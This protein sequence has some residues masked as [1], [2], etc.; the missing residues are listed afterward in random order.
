[1]RVIKRILLGLLILFLLAL[2]GLAG[3][4]VC[5]IDGL[6]S[7]SEIIESG[8]FSHMRLTIY[9]AYSDFSIQM[10]ANPDIFKNYDYKITIDDSNLELY[11]DSINQLITEPL[12]PYEQKTRLDCHIYYVFE[13]PIHR[14]L[15]EVALWGSG[16]SIYVNGIA[17]KEA[18]IYYDIILPFLPQDEADYFKALI[19]EIKQETSQN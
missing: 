10:P 6:Q 13:T 19:S 2:T 5:E 4:I 16:G 14:K 9:I 12:I 1:V 8:D 3:F 15:Y 18:D 11:K 17:V 7:F